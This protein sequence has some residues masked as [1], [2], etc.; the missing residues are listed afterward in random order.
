MSGSIPAVA[1]GVSGTFAWSGTIGLVLDRL[2]PAPAG[3]PAG[4]YAFFRPEDGT[5]HLTL[6][7]VDG[8][9]TG[10]GETD[11]GVDPSGGLSSVQQGVMQPTYTLYAA[12]GASP[13]IAFAWTGGT[14]ADPAAAMAR[15]R[16]G[17]ACP[18]W[19]RRP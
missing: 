18:S 17:P 10:H 16:S 3:S 8:H 1:G 6:D 4:Q 7:M 12:F 9:C 5:I 11:L 19:P 14:D 13:G 2:G 15:C